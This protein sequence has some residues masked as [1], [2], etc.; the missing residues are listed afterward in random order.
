MSQAISVGIVGLGK[1]SWLHDIADPDLKIT[2]CKSLNAIDR[3]KIVFGIDNDSSR[4]FEW[5]NEYDSPSFE[6]ISKAAHLQPD[7]IIIATPIESLFECFVDALST[8]PES[9]ILIEK[10]VC[11]TFGQLD[12]LE[13][14]GEDNLKRV[15]VN[16]PRLFQPETQEIRRK[17]NPYIATGGP[18]RLSGVY[19]GG[20]LNTMGHFMSLLEYFFGR[21]SYKSTGFTLDSLGRSMADLNI[22]SSSD[23]DVSG[24][25]CANSGTE[26]SSA[27][28]QIE[29]SEL[30][31]QYL[32]GGKSI[33]AVT[34]NLVLEIPSTRDTYQ[35]QVY[36][37]LSEND[38]E[39]AVEKSG[40][41]GQLPIIRSLLN[42]V[43]VGD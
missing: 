11:N 13:L 4:R 33:S 30:L 17:L 29:T 40:L 10:P 37:Y 34:P 23:I 19:S 1:A 16:Y 25:I 2:H 24:V 7:F 14:L 18:V 43:K 35:Y 22:S 9:R 12:Q 15:V 38:W 41:Y 31:I 27:N 42:L 3:Y 32:D 6:S 26:L 21:L 39:L 20:T 8:F 5:G 36:K 28:L